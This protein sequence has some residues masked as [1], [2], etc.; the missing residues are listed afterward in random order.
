MAL[1]LGG[2]TSY[3][4]PIAVAAPSKKSLADVYFAGMPPSVGAA[5]TTATGAPQ[6][7]LNPYD[8]STD[9]LVQQSLIN[10]QLTNQLSD[11]GLRDYLTQNL[12]RLGDPN[13][14]SSLNQKL[15]SA[16]LGTVAIDPAA[17][18]LAQANKFSTYAQTNRQADVANQ[19]LA[20]QLAAQ[21]ITQSGATP[22]GVGQI[23]YGRQQSL[24]DALDAF[25]QAASGQINNA[26]QSR[27]QAVMDQFNAQNTAYQNYVNNPLNYAVSQGAAATANTAVQPDVVKQAASGAS[28]QLAKMAAGAGLNTAAPK[29]GVSGGVVGVVKPTTNPYLGGTSRKA[30]VG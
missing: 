28:S 15:S 10:Q 3:K 21:G 11:Q 24:N 19:Q 1:I 13:L 7:T 18:A 30:L 26:L 8:I 22:A 9:P 23:E 29:L 5:S 20:N 27:R 6:L 2:G 17:A 16:G 25:N 4:P 14:I 12:I